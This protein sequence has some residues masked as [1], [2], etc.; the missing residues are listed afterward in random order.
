M[1][2]QITQDGSQMLDKLSQ[3][4]KLEAGGSA[5]FLPVFVNEGVEGHSV[6]P[7]G[8]EVV[9]VDIWIAVK[10][11]ITLRSDTQTFAR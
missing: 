9:D 4:L 8:G 10:K 3:E 2:R 11:Y 5:E 7:A 1:E 6:T